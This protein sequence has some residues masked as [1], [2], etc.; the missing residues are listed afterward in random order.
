MGQRG[1]AK[2]FD[3]KTYVN[4]PDQAHLV[5]V[6]TSA[7]ADYVVGEAAPAYQP[8]CG[9]TSF[10]RH[11]V[12][13]KA[14]KPYLVVYDR[15]TAKGPQRWDSYLHANDAFTIGEDG[16]S[17]RMGG[18]IAF[19]AVFGPAGVQ[20]TTHPLTVVEHPDDKR[21]DRGFELVLH[22]PDG[23]AST[24]LVSVIGIEPAKV[25]LVSS[26]PAPAVKVG[27]DTIAW[28]A[29]DGVTFNGAPIDHNLLP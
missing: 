28:D 13:V 9:L 10:R 17:F 18:K 4:R 29:Q 3:A 12:F 1:E 16:A 26:D 5:I 15:L 24:W 8:G 23:T 19:G 21:V 11:I 14:A 22:P 20:A 27:G 7:P 6:A 25:A 2:W